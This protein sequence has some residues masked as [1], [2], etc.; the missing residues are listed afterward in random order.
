MAWLRPQPSEVEQ[1]IQAAEKT[2][3][4]LNGRFTMNEEKIR[5]FSMGQHSSALTPFSQ[6][7]PGSAVPVNTVPEPKL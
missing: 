2:A 5:E 7:Q 3:K 4:R 1:I 6:G